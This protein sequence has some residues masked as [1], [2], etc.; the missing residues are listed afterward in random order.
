[1]TTIPN[2]LLAE[3]IIAYLAR[4]R[5]EGAIWTGDIAYGLGERTMPVRAALVRL[6]RARTVR[7]VVTG[8]P[9]SWALTDAEAT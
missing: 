1:V 5:R 3:R 7:R 9:T 6:E 4:H 8:T 2:D